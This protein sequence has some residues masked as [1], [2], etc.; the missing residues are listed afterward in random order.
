MAQAIHAAFLISQD[1]A[2]LVARWHEQSQYLVVLAA[3][4]EQALDELSRRALHRGVPHSVWTEPDL[5]D[6]VTALAFAPGSAAR[7]LCA[8]LPLALRPGSAV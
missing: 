6:E 2:D 4:S 5:G 7:R 3:P 1:H 8:N